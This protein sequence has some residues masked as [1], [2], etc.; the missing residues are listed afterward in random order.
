[1]TALVTGAAKRVGR[2]I[3]LHLALGGYHIAMHYHRSETAARKTQR[4]IE[5]LG[6]TCTLYQ[7]DLGQ[8]DQVLNLLPAVLRD[9][10]D[11]NLLVNNA[12]TLAKGRFAE[13]EPDFFDHHFTVNFK[14]PYFLIRDFARY[15]Q[16][17]HVINMLDT[18][19]AG[20]ASK[21]NVYLLAKKAL[22]DL[23]RMAALEL[24]PNIRVNG[25]APGHV[26]SPSNRDKEFEQRVRDQ[27]PLKQSG[28]PDT[29]TRTLQFLLDTHFITGEIVV[30]DGGYR[31]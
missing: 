11:L 14:S 6:V 15:V 16:T 31:L 24:A 4:E 9:F 1:M 10:P 12:S 7:A 25:I 3:A 21:Y 27:T 20:N 13:T 2:A 8:T 22:A 26:L 28:S 18:E 19:I 30:V 23:T 29:I 5:R 17:G